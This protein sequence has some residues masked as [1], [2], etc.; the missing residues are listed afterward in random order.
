MSVSS[1]LLSPSQ[2]HGS[3]HTIGHAACFVCVTTGGQRAV[4]QALCGRSPVRKSGIGTPDSIYPPSLEPTS[5]PCPVT[6]PTELQSV[7]SERTQRTAPPGCSNPGLSSQP[8]S[9]LSS[10]LPCT[11]STVCSTNMCIRGS[12]TNLLYPVPCHTSTQWIRR[13]CLEVIH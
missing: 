3:S 4:W 13:W 12:R 6:F 11:S 2:L 9:W 10:T 7:S 5:F 1:P 8:A